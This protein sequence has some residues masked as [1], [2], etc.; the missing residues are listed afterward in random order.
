MYNLTKKC[1]DTL[2]ILEYSWDRVF[3]D[4]STNGWTIWKTRKFIALGMTKDE[5]VK[6]WFLEILPDNPLRELCKKNE[7]TR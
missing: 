3:N 6:K 2:D 7:G 1:L 4:S 5:W